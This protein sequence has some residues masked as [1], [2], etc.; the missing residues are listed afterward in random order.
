MGFY[1][2]VL[3]NQPTRLKYSLINQSCVLVL[4]I[5][6]HALD[7][8]EKK[9]LLSKTEPM[10]RLVYVLQHY[11]VDTTIVMFMTFGHIILDW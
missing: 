7:E 9:A 4:L 5:L 11:Q 2:A 8:E 1:Y 3:L 6:P 10:E